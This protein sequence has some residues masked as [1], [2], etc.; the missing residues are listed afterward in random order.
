MLR[1]T[2]EGSEPTLLLT[3]MLNQTSSDDRLDMS[4]LDRKTITKINKAKLIPLF[5]K[6]QRYLV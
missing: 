5:K 1:L 2:R 4:L 3:D 6:G